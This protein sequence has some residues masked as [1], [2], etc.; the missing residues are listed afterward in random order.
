MPEKK[1]STSLKSHD[2]EA[3]LRL[4]LDNTTKSFILLDKD[5]RVLMFNK[6]A[7]KGMRFFYNKA[8]KLNTSY[9]DY[10]DKANNSSFIR[11]FDKALTGRKLTTEKSLKSPKGDTI[12]IE[13]SFV[14]MVDEN[15]KVSGVLYSYINI[16]EK[17]EAEKAL[18]ES[19]SN[20]RAVFNSSLDG[21]FLINPNFRVIAINPAARKTFNGL[22]NHKINLGDNLLDFIDKN[23]KLRFMRNI[24]IALK[25]GF[26]TSSGYKVLNGKPFY[27]EMKYNG[28]KN[29]Q[30]VIYGIALIASNVT[31]KSLAEKALTDS[32]NNLRAIFN[33]TNHLFF[34]VDNHF[35][36]VA[37]NQAASRMIKMQF[38]RELKKGD[39]ITDCIHEKNKL[40]CIDEI[41]KALR[42][43]NVFT[44]R[45]VEIN[46]KEFWFER[47]YNPVY[48]EKREIKGVTIWSSNI[49]ERKK[50]EDDTRVNE[51][52][53]RT[54]TS[55]A[56]VGI[57]QHNENGKLVYVNDKLLSI[58][59]INLP[60]A[61]SKSPLKNIHPADRLKMKEKWQQAEKDKG[62]FYM[63]YRI[64]TNEGKIKFVIEHAVPLKNNEDEFLGYMGTVT[65]ITEQKQKDQLQVEKELAEKSLKYK[66]EFLAAMSHEIRTP[67]NGILSMSELLLDTKLN[68]EQHEFIENIFNSSK[69]LRSIVNDILDM[70][71]LEAGKMR[72][73]PMAFQPDLM[74]DEIIKT[75]KA[76]AG[77]K[78]ISL[79]TEKTGSVPG[80]IITD[81]RRLMQVIVNLLRNA[82]K[83]T[84]AGSITIKT[85]VAEQRGTALKMKFSVTDTGV[86]I[87][88]SD[89]KKLFKDFSQIES[90]FSRDMEGTGLGLS[91]SRKLVQLLG[92]EIGVE[93]KVG[94]GSTFWFY[95]IAEAETK[96]EET[97]KAPSHS[98]KEPQKKADLPTGK[99]EVTYNCNVL[100]AED[101][102]I[103]QRA[104]SM[105]LKKA[106]CTVD[107]ASNG[108]EASEA[109]AKKVY[110]IIFM[111]IQMPEMDG[112]AAAAHIRKNGNKIPPIIALSGNMVDLNASDT[113]TKTM[114]DYLLKP[115]VSN[116]LLNMLKKWLPEKMKSTKQ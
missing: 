20:L 96:Q 10:V 14:P 39:H 101:N 18:N 84:P 73:S 112:F 58:L 66:S 116:D 50:A 86:G 59:E 67:L 75:Y 35:K 32:E 23:E 93:S 104:F 83:F 7:D 111:D 61:N 82:I 62:E 98:K 2:S 48:N 88:P 115:I 89:I 76:L 11:H 80:T 56:P 87:A 47:Q 63:E 91:I 34:M 3:Y 27:Y 4:I 108:K 103:N 100:L 94:K 36:V 114:D 60:E 37:F 22:Y 90:S 51:K 41:E 52:K 109:V 42:G 68:N 77:E 55:L 17:K 31:E 65:D 29:A 78:N 64:V 105:M 71:K 69:N 74:I 40:S 57:Y 25:G 107:V 113:E 19:E 45:A 8:L 49:T 15:Q 1:D 46:G 106:G 54:L 33:N 6:S 79:I 24:K 30:G 12:W 38:D 81:R 99:Q 16:S 43:N 70:S 28:V 72:L 92:G 102:L 21:Y 85:E 95:V 26:V 53:F 44:E 5:Y 13:A 9:W 110:D 97:K